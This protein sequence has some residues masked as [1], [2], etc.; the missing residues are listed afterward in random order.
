MKNKT[1]GTCCGGPYTANNVEQN[2]Y[3][4]SPSK[5]HNAEPPVFISG[6][7]REKLANYIAEYLHYEYSQ[8]YNYYIKTEEHIMILEAI[9]AYGSIEHN[10]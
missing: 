2:E 5:R 7:E 1:N 10:E 9:N 6:T 8:N 4:T 3:Q